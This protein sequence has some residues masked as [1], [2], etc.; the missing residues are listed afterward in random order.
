MV[1]NKIRKIWA[2]IIG[3]VGVIKELLILAIILGL[4]AGIISIIFYEFLNLIMKMTLS[5]FSG[6]ISP[7]PGENWGIVPPPKY[8]WIIPIITAIGGLISGIIVYT[9]A[10]EAEGHG[11]DAAIAAFHRFAGRIRFRVPIIKMIASSITIGT[12]G[13][14]GRE[15]PM[16][17]IG[18]GLGSILASLMKMDVYKKRIAVAIG[19][20]A[21]VGTIFKAPLGGAIFGMEVLYKRDFEVEA[22]LPAFIASTI[23]YAIFG[24]YSGYKHIFEMPIV[25]FK[26]PI[27]IPF[28]ILLGIT[29]AIIGWIYIKIF[30]GVKELFFKVRI[31]PYIKTMIGGFVTGLAGIFFPQILEMGYGWIT[32]FSHGVFPL[33]STGVDWIIGTDWSI[34]IITLFIL[35]LLKIIV[36]AFTIGS[37]GSGGVFAPGLFIGSLV[38]I[39]LGLVYLNL[40]PG[41]IMEPDTFI[42]SAAI[43]GMMS[44]FAG[45]SKAPISVLIMVSEMTGGYE[46]IA[47]AMLSI[48]LSYL[49]TWNYTIYP[50]QVIDRFHSPAHIKEYYREILDE[51]IVREAMRKD[52][53]SINRNMSVKEALTTMIREKIRELYVTEDNKLIGRVSFDELIRIPID[54][55]ENVKVEDIM[56]KRYIVVYPD[57]NLHN[58]LKLMM[59][60][61]LE[62]VPVVEREDGLKIVGL[63][64]RMDIIEAHDNAVRFI[65]GE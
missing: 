14:A 39:S 18:S 25:A 12:G 36:T 34:I 49:L 32:I 41:T 58:V 22:L 65:L 48:S 16:A 47:P 6:Y 53:Y 35:A 62:Q 44:L 43:I 9:F 20:G 37:G 4:L 52:F 60:N 27:E 7:D 17:Q 10:P 61:K 28:Y 40:F 59:K 38:G 30:F 54:M 33:T 3:E 64:T 15:G 11:T 5:S 55:Q 56:S 42:A 24:L 2:G 29:T 21:G 13:S 57:D 46:L 1:F 51:I 23:G 19:L 50:E 8:P 45:V 63:I 26:N 31:P